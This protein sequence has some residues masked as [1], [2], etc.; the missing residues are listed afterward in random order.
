MEL[1]AIRRARFRTLATGFALTFI[2]AVLGS[3]GFFYSW[4]ER[5]IDDARVYYINQISKNN[6]VV[7]ELAKAK[8]ELIFA[9]DDDGSKL[10]GIENATG[11]TRN[12]YGVIKFK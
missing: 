1:R 7:S 11:L 2:F 5:R 9:T 8:R 12:N 10:L 6:I 4:S 3:W